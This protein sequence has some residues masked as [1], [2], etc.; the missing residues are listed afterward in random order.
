MLQAPRGR[1]TAPQF[2]GLSLRLFL[3]NESDM[4]LRSREIPGRYADKQPLDR[5]RDG[6][7][8][9][10]FTA[11]HILDCR[12]GLREVNGKELDGRIHWQMRPTLIL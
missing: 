12:L 3:E 7:W 4:I 8:V 1:A 2:E 9:T 11:L 6:L 10:P 5:H